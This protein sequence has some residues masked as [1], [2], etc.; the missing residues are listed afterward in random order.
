M[1]KDKKSLSPRAQKLLDEIVQEESSI[2]EISK[3]EITK[4][5]HKEVN[6]EKNDVLPKTK[7][8]LFVKYAIFSPALYRSLTQNDKKPLWIL[9]FALLIMLLSSI[10]FKSFSYLNYK[11]STDEAYASKIPAI[12]KEIMNLDIK[13][14]QLT[15]EKNQEANKVSAVLKSFPN[16]IQTQNIVDDITRLFEM[17]NLLIIK[18]DI[19]IQK[20]QSEI[21]E[22]FVPFSSPN[23]EASI[24]V[25]ENVKSEIPISAS[26]KK[27]PATS[28]EAA[29]NNLISTG[30]VN[31]EKTKSNN[32][33]DDKKD[34]QTTDVFGSLDAGPPP[35]EISGIEYLTIQLSLRGSYLNYMKARSALT[36]V[37]PSVNI[38][39]EEIFSNQN[40]SMME[41]RVIYDIPMREEN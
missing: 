16:K 8:K 25:K 31:T 28:S 40:K 22:A 14:T 19:K 21:I 7:Q 33:K 41:F 29:L 32:L 13:I 30:N 4:D 27:M 23:P 1:D 26:P 36:R 9:I 17:S 35:S 15:Q 34:M 24:F 11:S 38:P 39:L 3:S 12:K 2:H 5:I 37:I 18:Q 10:L 20:K 6:K